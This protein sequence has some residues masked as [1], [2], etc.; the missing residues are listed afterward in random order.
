[1]ARSDEAAIS[2]YGW[3]TARTLV[4]VLCYNLFRLWYLKQLKTTNLFFS[5][6][7]LVPGVGEYYPFCGSVLYSIQMKV[8]E[9]AQFSR[10]FECVSRTDL[11]QIKQNLLV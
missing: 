7:I 5:I 11:T 4:A 3:S 10:S 8:F 2:F 6:S 1:M 9:I